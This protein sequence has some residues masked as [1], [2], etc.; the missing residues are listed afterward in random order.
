MPLGSEKVGL[1]GAAGAVGG[2]YFGD[3]SDGALSTSGNVTETVQ[4]KVGSY[5]GDML[6]KNY[7][8][9][10][11]GSGH[12]FTVDQPCRG[13][14]I[15]VQGNCTITGT[16]DVRMGGFADPTG[17]AASDSQAV[18][19]SGLR[20]AMLTSGGSDTLAA[21]DFKGSGTA[22]N[23]AVANQVEIA[24]DG[25][26]YTIQKTGGAGGAA[27]NLYGPANG[28]QYFSAGTNG[29]DGTETSVTGQTGGGGTGGYS[30]SGG[31][32]GG[33]IVG[34]VGG[35]GG[36]FSGGAGAGSLAY[37]IGS[38]PGFSL[39][40]NSP[41]D[42]GGGG[43]GGTRNWSAQTS[44]SGGAGNPGG[45]GGGNYG[46]DGE[47]ICGGILWLVVGGDVS[48]SGTVTAKGGSSGNANGGGMAGGS[49]GGGS[50]G[51][52]LMILHGGSYSNSGTVTAD[53]GAAGNAQSTSQKGGTGGDGAVIVSQVEA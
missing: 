19:A 7:T 13:M 34:Q 9:L 28:Q 12:T 52:I 21:P 51:G 30:F 24:G 53:G 49:T 8:S 1:M 22:A 5:D 3:G 29:V 36:A 26:I 16:L 11:I 40:V 10:T 27:H 48:I 18:N 14:L 6:V 20:L 42:Y 33:N 31:N 44:A 32:S 17:T 37:T 38:S 50:G 46:N 35:L 43:G 25:T 45:G 15:Y 39:T 23:T 2:N 4:N 41:P 47:D